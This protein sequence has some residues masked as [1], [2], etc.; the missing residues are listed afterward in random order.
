MSFGAAGKLDGSHSPDASRALAKRG[1]Q[2][3]ELADPLSLHRRAME[4]CNKPPLLLVCVFVYVGAILAL[5]H[6]RL[7]VNYQITPSQENR[8]D[9]HSLWELNDCRFMPRRA[10]FLVLSHRNARCY[11]CS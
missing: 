11:G 8:I 3:R 10:S 1:Q 5:G 7:V 6:P 4:R 2:N 9:H